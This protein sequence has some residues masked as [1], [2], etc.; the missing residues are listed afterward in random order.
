MFN[1]VYN[2]YKNKAINHSMPENIHIFSKFDAST[3]PY[4]TKRIGAENADIYNWA[5]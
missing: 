5:I 3:D 4:I 2:K 1:S